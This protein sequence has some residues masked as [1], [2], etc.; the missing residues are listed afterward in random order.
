MTPGHLHSGRH[1]CGS[2]PLRK[3]TAAEVHRVGSSPLRK[4]TA[5]E[6]HRVGI[7]MSRATSWCDGIGLPSHFRGAA[8]EWPFSESQGSVDF[9]QDVASQ[10]LRT[11]FVD[12]VLHSFDCPFDE[13]QSRLVRKPL[14]QKF[15]GIG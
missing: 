6:V 13:P 15:R 2:S 8:D 3:F 5:S 11:D 10:F 4:F 12:N 14:H 1:R 9:L 7:E